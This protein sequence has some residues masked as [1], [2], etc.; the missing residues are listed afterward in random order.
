LSLGDE[1]AA[2]RALDAGEVDGYPE[3]TGTALLSLCG[4]E[5]IDVPKDP[6]QAYQDA[7]ECLAEK[8]Q[9]A[10][11]P[12]PFTSSNEVGVKKATARRYG[13]RTIS[14]LAKVDQ[15]F[16]L[17]GSPEC[18][19]R[20]DCLA[21]L[22]RVYGLRFGTFRPV[23]IDRRFEVLEDGGPVASI[24]FT[25]D[26]QILRGGITLLEDD[27]GM[28]PPNNSTFVA[29]DEVVDTAGPAL[30]STV[31]KIEAGLTDETMQ[32]L[33]ALVDLD[34]QTPA[35]VARGY[36]RDGGLVGG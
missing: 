11:A 32:E 1:K 35:A 34:G 20:A 8:G 10:F 18:A 3:Y 22:Q 21:G 7:Q 36:L 33:N 25:T 9:T 17:F 14:D 12:T 24:V 23:M 26:P 16:T 27:R 30:G 13:L 2:Q 31:E 15:D 28:F 4:V 6:Q 5:T 29:R 19:G